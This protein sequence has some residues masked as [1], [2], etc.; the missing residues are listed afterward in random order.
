M[1]TLRN[2]NIILF[3]FFILTNLSFKTLYQGLN[4]GLNLNLVFMTLTTFLVLVCYLVSMNSVRNNRNGFYIN[5][6]LIYIILVVLFR[7]ENILV[8]YV[9]FEATLIPMFFLIL[10][11]GYRE[12]KTRAAFMFFYFTLVGGLFMLIVLMLIYSTSG[13]FNLSILYLTEYNYQTQKV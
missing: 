8:F 12:E 4:H 7:T 13:T 10:G 1:V 6:L 9:S 2:T 11:W 5:L 3:I